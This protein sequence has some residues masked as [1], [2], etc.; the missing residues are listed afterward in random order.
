MDRKCQWIPRTER[1]SQEERR[2]E[3]DDEDGEED[4]Y[5]WFVPR[6]ERRIWD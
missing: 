3:E 2:G 5:H 4:E 1:L 6:K